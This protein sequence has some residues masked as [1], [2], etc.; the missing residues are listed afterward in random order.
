MVAAEALIQLAE[1][2][3]LMTVEACRRA[4]VLVRTSDDLTTTR[5]IMDRLAEFLPGEDSVLLE[6]SWLDVLFNDRVSR[7]Q[8]TFSR[9]TKLPNFAESAQMGLALADLRNNQPAA[10]LA[11]V[12]GHAG[13][14]ERLAPRFR[15]T[16]AAVLAANDRREPAR[17]LVLSLKPGDLRGLERELVS[18]L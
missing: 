14:L 7:A 15:A 16:A 18:G 8:E 3:P 11:R 12:E 6:R 17:R 10:A 4:L 13:D 1:L 5:K 9:L 2:N